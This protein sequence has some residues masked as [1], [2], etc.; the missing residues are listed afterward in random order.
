MNRKIALVII[1]LACSLFAA[2]VSEESAMLVAQNWFSL[3]NPI[4]TDDRQITSSSVTKEENTN[5]FYTFNFQSG[6]FVIVAADDASMPILGYSYSSAAPEDV[7]NTPIG[8]W[9]DRYKNQ[10]STIIKNNYSNATTLPQW[11]KILDSDITRYNSVQSV[12]PLLESK[13]GQASPYNSKIPKSFPVGS[14]VTAMGQ[15]MNYYQWPVKGNGTKAHPG[16]VNG[17]GVNLTADFANTTYE[18]PK[19]TVPMLTGSS[20]GATAATDTMLLHLGIATTTKFGKDISTST[21]ANALSAFK[22]NFR[23]NS[24]AKILNRL[25]YTSIEWN[26]S[27]RTELDLL[28]PIYYSITDLDMEADHA[29]VC[30]GYTVDD[31]KFH[32]NW[33]FNGNYNGY[34]EASMLNPALANSFIS[35]QQAI[36]GLWYHNPAPSPVYNISAQSYGDGKKITVTWNENP[37]SENVV[38]YRV[39]FDETSCGYTTYK[40]TISNS[41]IIDDLQSDVTYFLSVSGITAK[42]MTSKVEEITFKISETPETPSDFYVAPAANEITLSWSYN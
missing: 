14:I 28:Q 38:K 9:L 40:E 36:F 20:A 23:Y 19:M 35:S 13:W 16:S 34:Y 15:V 3:R 26:D 42:G 27:L 33:G 25:S 4:K 7:S 17:T 29:F 2:P 12:G 10:I 6:G 21:T 11:S 30:D 24:A 22:N 32:F 39:G 5:L 1:T 8:F 31:N 18:W 37:S 41:L